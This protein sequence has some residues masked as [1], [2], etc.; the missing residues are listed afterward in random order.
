MTKFLP[1]LM[2]LLTSCSMNQ[3]YLQ[4]TDNMPIYGEGGIGM[5]QL[6][7]ID[8]GDTIEVVTKPRRELQSAMTVVHRSKLVWTVGVAHKTR[9]I[10][11]K[12]IS[13]KYYGRQYANYAFISADAPNVISGT[14]RHYKSS[15]EPHGT[16]PGTGAV[17]HT[18]PRGGRYYINSNGNKT[19]IKK[20][21]SRSSSTSSRGSTSKSYKKSSS[22]SSY[23]RSSSG[24]YRKS[25]GGS[26]YRRR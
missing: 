7:E 9:I 23:R 21:A 11:K 4:T 26:S 14:S 1:L 3:Y 15:S 16:T 12:R 25:S 19:Y 6:G 13:R 24:S 2:L 8:L 5:E 22:S 20:N 17:I 10:R 18:G